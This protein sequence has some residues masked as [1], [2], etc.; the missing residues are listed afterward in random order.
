VFISST[1]KDLISERQ[2]AVEAILQAGHI[3]AGMELFSAGNESQKEVISRWIDESDVFMLILG[4]RYGTVE[5]KSGK[6]YVEIEYR[7]ALLVEKPSFA[8]V[9]DEKALEEKV[10]CF[11]QDVL[12]LENRDKYEKFR[13]FVLSKVSRFFSDVKDVK[14]AVLESLLEITRRYE[15]SGWVSG[16]EI[17]DF[18]NILQENAELRKEIYDLQKRIREYDSSPPELYGGYTFSEI[19]EILK[20]KKINPLESIFDLFIDN[21]KEFVIGIE[22]PWGTQSPKSELFYRVAPHLITFGLLEKVSVPGSG[23]Q[24]IQVSPLGLRF[25]ARLEK[26]S[27]ETER[28]STNG[29][30]E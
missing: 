3:P 5:P 9:I 15:L 27:H 24:R 29:V 20:S 12:E 17:P 28:E 6:S 1:Y 2:A 8:I 7:H 14:I 10:K 26:E 21:C 13:N 30:E 16:R 19:K 22:N 25:L 4:G 11:G 18:Q 23:Y